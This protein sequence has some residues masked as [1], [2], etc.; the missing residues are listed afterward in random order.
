MWQYLLHRVFGIGEENRFDVRFGAGVVGHTTYVILAIC[1]AS[2][3]VAWALSEHPNVAF[4]IV[5]LLSGLVV[6]FLVG[7]WW[8]AHRHPDQAAMGGSEWRRFREL[9]MGARDPA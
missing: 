9:Q 3:I 7:T 8:F 2:G 1:T 6:L 5:A 4:R